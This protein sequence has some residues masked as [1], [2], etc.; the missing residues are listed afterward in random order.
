[1]IDRK[2]NDRDFGIPS[3]GSRGVSAEGRTRA[4]QTP[5]KARSNPKNRTVRGP[6][7]SAT[8]TRK[9]AAPS[10][11]H[12]E[13]CSRVPLHSIVNREILKK[14]RQIRACFPS[15]CRPTPFSCHRRAADGP[16]TSGLCPEPG[17]PFCAALTRARNLV[18]VAAGLE[19]Y[20]ADRPRRPG[21]DLDVRVAE[22]KMPVLEPHCLTEHLHRIGV[23]SAP[24]GPAGSRSVMAPSSPHSLSRPV[25]RSNRSSRRCSC[26][27]A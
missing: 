2:C 20:G 27:R 11:G 10:E 23:Q 19:Q 22:P 4:A 16:G 5:K 8:T 7:C 1:M 25:R 26:L 15:R 24:F 9:R 18:I 17:W 12:F 3:W 13:S 14:I 21:A 6:D